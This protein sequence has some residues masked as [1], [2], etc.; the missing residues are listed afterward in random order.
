MTR[1]QSNK[2][3]AAALD[4]VLTE[5]DAESATALSAEQR[6]LWLLG[7]MGAGSWATV[8]G[9]YRIPPELEQTRLQQRLSRLTAEHEALRSVFVE[10]AGRPVRLV[11]PRGDVALR[12]V[13]T[14][15]SPGELVEHLTEEEFSLGQGPLLRALLL[16]GVDGGTDELVLAG[17]RLVL[18]E[19]SCDLL[20][21][22][23][24][25]PDDADAEAVSGMPTA[26]PTTTL[27]EVLQAEMDRLAAPDVREEADRR[28][29]LLDRPAASAVPGYRARPPVKV[30]AT[31]SLTVPLRRPVAERAART[32]DWTAAVVAAWLVVL[33]RSQAS[34]SAQC[35]VRVPRP[36]AT[37]GVVGPL[38]PLRVVRVDGA[39]RVPLPRLVADVAERLAGSPDEPPFAY[40][41][42]VRPPRRDVSRTPYVQT[43]VRAVDARGTRAVPAQA[44][45]TEYDLELTARLEDTG[46]RLQLSYDS[47]V[48]DEPR[49]RGLAAQFEAVLDALAPDSPVPT[50]TP[51]TTRLLPE[52]DD[53]AAVA[54]GHGNDA[55]REPG[56]LTDLV[57][58]Q[59]RATP[60]AV[61]LRQGDATLAYGP[62]WADALRLAGELATRGVRPGDRVAVRLSRGPG[63]V[64]ALL[65]VLAAGGVYVP[66]DTAYPEERV[67]YMLG[68]CR[69]ALLVT[70]SSAAGAPQGAG[71]PVL[72]LDELPPAGSGAAPLPGPV[73]LAGD[74]PA[75]LIYTSGS[76]GRPKGVVVRHTSVVNNI[77]W[78]QANWPIGSSDRVLHNHSFSF[79]PSVW[80]VFWP[81]STGAAVVLADEEQMADP[82]ELLTCVREG[83]VTLLGGVPSLLSLLV[84]HPSAGLCTS[85]RTVLSGAEPLTEPLLERMGKVWS[86]EVANLYGPTEATIDA[87]GHPVATGRQATVPVPIGRAVDNTEVHVVDAEL[88]PVPEGVPGEIVVGGAGLALGYHGRPA[89]TAARFVPNPFTGSGARLYRTGDLGRRLP[90]GT[91]QFLGRLDDQVKVRGHRVE[92]G[93]VEAVL[94]GLDEVRAAVVVALDAGTEGARL[95]AAFVP[96][97]P[98]AGTDGVHAA[99]ADALPRHLV[100]DRLLALPELP[101]TP[102]GKTDRQEAARLLARADAPDGDT[103]RTPPRSELERAVAESFAQVLY[104]GTA[105]PEPDVH[106]DFFAAG[107]N[108]VLLARLATIL[109]ERHGVDVPLHEFFRTPTVAGVAE[110][111]EVYRRDG[112]SGVL[113]RRHAATLEADGDL[114]ADITPAGL[115]E[116]DWEHPSRVL[117]TGATGY[118][119][120]HVLAELLRGTDAEVVCLC[121]GESPEDALG[122]V[123]RTMAQYEVDCAAELHRVTC[124]TGDLGLPRL[125]L[126]EEQW[127]DLAESVDVIH[128][129]GAMVNFVYPYSALKAPNVGGTQEVLRLA[130][131][132][133]LKAVHHISTIDTLLATHSPRPF[134]EDDAPLRSAVGVPAGYTGSK[135]VAEKVVDVARRRGVPVTVFRPGL[136]LGHTRNGA[137][138]SIDYLLVALRGFL[139]MRILPEYPRIFDIVPV[140]YVASAVVH[141]AGRRDALGGFYHLFNPAP[142]S[143]ATF[144]D[145]IRSYG[146]EFDTVPF[147]EGRRRALAVGP[148]HLLYPLVPLIKDAEAEPHRA[149]DPRYLAEVRPELECART[150]SMLDGSGIACPPTSEADAH[151]VLDYLV[152]T[153]FMAGP[154][155]VVPEPPLVSARES[156]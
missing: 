78:R 4:R 90:D 116:A 127:A 29:R 77:G 130:C 10:V 59:A 67:R 103:R 28:A 155:D 27:T 106:A 54:A 63:A 53:R 60:E 21:E 20:A 55:T 153:G 82:A 47:G 25:R 123:K 146:Y 113:G 95:T 5:R 16:R 46:A 133:R 19:T 48:H 94:A 6:R 128:H 119:G 131:E 61:A 41:L 40:L 72:L 57:A 80:A 97:D 108:S 93:E 129:S 112:L 8:T 1:R 15:R 43:V 149:L 152:R 18:D 26:A 142:V 37:A 81:L 154:E 136:I 71:V 109:T 14:P 39:D 84:D 34:G 102:S 44:G 122:R 32:G 111:I 141:I 3:F 23:L 114:D 79:D 85:V 101:R 49:V 36:A 7:S 33:M 88:R 104:A 98:A 70:E 134:L 56:S 138:Q 12:V 115:P 135:W 100:P 140:D 151:L 75:Y 76:T 68:D 22:A 87:T 35:G 132:R 74:A 143:L 86:A 65:A 38:D 2:A 83:E 139:P 92:V 52:G 45:G 105:A 69:P 73:P 9:R 17:H 118:L 145:W 30:N 147:E 99:L 117:L 126:T 110:T 144:C 91:V 137:T 124:L 50:A 121:R 150:L 51:A 107:G 96:A 120:V 58:R 89:L 148:G 66:V 125:G 13:D 64:T 62:L 24:V 42:E 156:S 31:A 11:L